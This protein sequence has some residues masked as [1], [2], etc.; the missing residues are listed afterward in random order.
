MRPRLTG[1]GGFIDAVAVTNRVAK[2]RL[3]TSDVDRVGRGWCD[4]DRADRGSGLA[5]KDRKPRSAS[6]D[7]L[8]HAAI[9][10]AEI[11]IIRTPGN[12]GRRS[13]APAAKGAK[14]TPVKAGVEVR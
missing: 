6:V 7:G 2:R 13:D 10:R 8:P 11:E 1:I 4:R 14:H 5:V 12:S 9:D 3:P